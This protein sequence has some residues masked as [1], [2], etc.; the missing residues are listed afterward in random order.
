MGDVSGDRERFYL[1][2]LQPFKL[3][4]YSKY[5]RERSWRSD[6]RILWKTGVAILLPR[7][8]P[9]PGPLMELTKPQK[10]TR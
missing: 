6:V 4:G 7:H 3:E 8:V 10:E 1:E 9:P 2:T 5:L